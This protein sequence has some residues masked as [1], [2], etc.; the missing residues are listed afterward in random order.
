MINLFKQKSVLLSFRWLLVFFYFIAGVNHFIHPKFYYPLIPPYLPEPIL[1]N[2]LSGVLEILLAIAIIIPRYRRI[3]SV[4]IILLLIAFIPSH[5]YF[6]QVGACMSSESLCT[7]MW[8]AWI[9]LLLIHPML[10]AW[11]WYVGRK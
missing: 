2:A 5:V 3:A 10:I 1:I 11:A 7:P 4:F 8:V 9:R 6:I